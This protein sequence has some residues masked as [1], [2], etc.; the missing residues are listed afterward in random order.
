M[1]RQMATK[2]MLFSHFDVEI[3]ANRLQA[4]VW[5]EGVDRH[6]P[7]IETNG[8]PPTNLRV[9]Q[10]ETGTWLAQCVIAV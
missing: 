9:R 2:R 8:A 7:T 1:I 10:D 5:G 4:T 3:N 6:K